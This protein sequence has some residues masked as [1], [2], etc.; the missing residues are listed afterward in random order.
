MICVNESEALSQPL[1][2]VKSRLKQDGFETL[3][4]WIHGMGWANGGRERI[5]D[6]M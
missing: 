2:I 6:G 3:S 5:P 4:Q 1:C